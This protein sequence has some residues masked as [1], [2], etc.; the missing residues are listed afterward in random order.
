MV[1]TLADYRRFG[2]MVLRDGGGLLSPAAAQLMHTDHL[3]ALQREK[4][5]FRGTRRFFTFRGFGLGVSIVDDPTC[6]PALTS[7]GAFGW[8][9]YFGSWWHSFPREDLVAVLM[10]QRPDAEE[11]LPIAMDFQTLVMAAVDD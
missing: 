6:A 8:G 3:T 10:M 7:V 5:R 2:A 11:N 9:G 1:S 4:T